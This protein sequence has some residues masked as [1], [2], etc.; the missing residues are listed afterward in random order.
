MR[1]ATVRQNREYPNNKTLDQLD[2]RV[3]MGK[4]VV[5]VVQ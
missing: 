2:T 1:V 4:S 5:W 3:A